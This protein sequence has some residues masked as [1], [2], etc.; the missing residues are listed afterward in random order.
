MI[1][2]VLSGEINKAIKILYP[3]IVYQVT[4]VRTSNSEFGDYSFAAMDLTSRVG[5]NPR[6]I[7]EEIRKKLMDSG[8]FNKYVAKTEIAGPGFLN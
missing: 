3:N 6:Q 8:N 2:D 1:R 7:A 4:V 5:Q